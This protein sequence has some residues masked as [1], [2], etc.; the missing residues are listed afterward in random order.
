MGIGIGLGIG[1]SL[2]VS[3]AAEI[4]EPLTPATFQPAVNDI[5]STR[6]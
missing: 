4:N 6:P 1:I 5:S 3:E 2:R